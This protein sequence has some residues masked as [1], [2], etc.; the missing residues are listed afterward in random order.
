MPQVNYDGPLTIATA[1]TRKS[2]SWKNTGTTW[3]ELVQRL[4]TPTRTQETQ[5]EYKH[6]PKAQRDDIK[7]VGGFVGGLLKGGRR[8]VDAVASRRLVTLDLDS[9]PKGGDPWPAVAL[10]IGCAAVLYST[11]SHAEAAPRLR[12]VVP[13][14][15]EV[16]PDEYLAIS[17]RLAGDIGIDWCDDTTF[18]PHRLMYW[19][20]ASRDAPYRFEFQDAPWLDVDAELARYEDWRDPSQWPVSSRRAEIM[21]RLATKQ[22]DPAEKPGVVG[23]FCRVYPIEEAIAQFLP[24]VYTPCENGRYTFAGGSTAGGLVLYEDGKFAFSHHATDPCSGRL[25]NSFDLVRLH[26]FGDEDDAAGPG[27]PVNRL[28]SYTKMS[29]LALEDENVR[30]DLTEHKL[31]EVSSAFDDMEA[32]DEDT[33][34]LK[35]L[36]VNK[37]G[38]ID[39]TVD[40]ITIILA[41]DPTLRGRFYYDEFRDRPVVSGDLPWIAFDKRASVVWSDAD[42]AGLRWLLEQR[43]GV[44]YAR[45]IGDAVELAMLKNKRHPVREYLQGLTWDGVPRAETVFIDY[46]GAEDTRYTRQVTRKALIG[47]VARIMEPGCKH[48]HMLVLVG[49]Q[50]CRKS[51]TLMKLGKSWFSDSLY[52]MMGK[53]AYEQLQGAWILEL[54]EMAATRKAEVEQIKQF[55]SKQEDVYRAAYARRTQIKPRQCAFF[56]ST[57][58]EEFLRDQTGARRFWPVNVTDAGRQKGDALTSDIVDQIWAE[59]MVYYLAGEPWHLDAEA[60]ALAKEAQLAHTE[61]N[62]WQG[63]IEQFLETLLPE[64]WKTRTVEERKLFWQGSFD[65]PG[66]DHRQT[67]CALEVWVELFNGDPKTFSQ[68]QARIINNIIQNLPGWKKQTR[69]Q[70]GPYGQQRGFSWK[71][72]QKS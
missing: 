27:T 55:I 48:D 9:V 10:V 36:S 40:N 39:A 62:D 28:P 33:E 11:H 65:E 24:E 64:N 68:Q 71:L 61:S 59:V 25:C 15:R 16:S 12:L 29:E 72:P 34:W 58:D 53:D 63:L 70:C 60:E 46:L 52:T 37:G 47:A 57:N 45:K 32:G 43:Y 6:L 67:V 13:L 7:D 21:R 30:K 17:H 20:S 38:Q 50:G 26:L 5:D 1:T 2:V 8:K 49:P 4:Q 23:A 66:T 44:D 3:S 22:G 19:P 35:E 18:E 14:S 54:S 56:G 31:R 51:T 41:N 69:V 42:D